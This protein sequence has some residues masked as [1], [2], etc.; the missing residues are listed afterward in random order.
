MAC[1]TRT[2]ESLWLPSLS[3]VCLLSRIQRTV[4]Q[5]VIY[6]QEVTWWEYYVCGISCNTT[7]KADNKSSHSG[8]GV[9]W[10]LFEDTCLERRWIH[11]SHSESKHTD[12]QLTSK[13][14]KRRDLFP[15]QSYRHQC[16]GFVVRQQLSFHSSHYFPF[17][18]Q[19]KSCRSREPE[20]TIVQT[21]SNVVHNSYSILEVNISSFLFLNE[22]E[23]SF[24][25]SQVNRRTSKKETVKEE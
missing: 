12:S 4:K 19:N 9:K 21:R 6:S 2:Q 22:T 24:I 1:W 11:S 8:R 18:L 15:C 13:E 23:D 5:H 17:F 16:S 3:W 20:M 14:N 25:D 10:S 7:N